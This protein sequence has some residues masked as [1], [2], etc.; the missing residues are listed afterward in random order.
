MRCLTLA[1][2][3]R[4]KSIYV[5]FICRDLTGNLI[6]LL[7]TRMIPVTILPSPIKVG[8]DNVSNNPS[9][10][11]EVSQAEDAMQTIEALRGIRPDWL[12]V[13]QYGLD[14][15][16]ERELHQ[17]AGHLMVIDDLANR[18]HE[19]DVLLDQNYFSNPENRYTDLAPPSCNFLLGPQY[20]LLR[21]EF[22]ELRLRFVKKISLN[23]VLV[24]LTSGDDQ[25]ATMKAM[26]GID[27]YGQINHVDIVVGKANPDIFS[28]RKICQRKNWNFHCQIDYMSSLISEADLVIGAGGS[29]NWER[30]VL[31]VPA[32]VVVLAEN[33]VDI[34]RALDDAGVV[35]NLGW[36]MNVHA[37][38]YKKALN[39]I[40]EQVL[41][42]M[43]Q[44]A[45]ELVDAKGAQKIVSALLSIN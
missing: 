38:D 41:G 30:C 35:I 14:A 32:L 15:E 6:D 18:K 31:G 17:Y 36:H 40:N 29:S 21:K 37:H 9:S 3:L 2:A 27:L 22:E 16:W 33:Q 20:A 26:E 8:Q 42:A 5:R 4:D 13:D 44:S 25:G 23:R 11:L 34:A 43:S 39:S 19:C 28:I 7:N 45:F 24:F 12:I 1:E 10:W